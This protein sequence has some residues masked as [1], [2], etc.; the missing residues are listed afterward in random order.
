L[1]I[2]YDKYYPWKYNSIT[3]E[4]LLQARY[5]ATN[6]IS[7][8]IAAPDS[9][10][11]L[12]IFKHFIKD[13]HIDT[14]TTGEIDTSNRKRTVYHSMEWPD[15]W[16]QYYFQSG[17]L[18]HDPLIEALPKNH[19]PFTWD[20][21][22]ARNGLTIAGTEALTKVAAEGWVDGLVVPMHRTATHFGL[23]SLVTMNHRLSQGEKTQLTA[24]SVVLHDRLR[25]LLPVEGF[26]IP[27]AGL[28]PR[29]IE[30]IRLI[31]AGMS[32][33]T[34]GEALG[35]RGSTVHEHAERAKFKLDA[36]N[37]A[38]LVALAVGFGIILA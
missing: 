35:I 29:E 37:R 10:S 14:F 28:T 13:F 4:D 17:M 2:D 32:D 33:I 1:T 21:L 6:V 8:I 34:A 30:C 20:E 15:R 36:K 27:P 23:V 9:R 38:E 16:R 19:A 25:R 3:R 18:E 5:S 31:A 22:R 7:G 11:A 26:R 12:D 24:A